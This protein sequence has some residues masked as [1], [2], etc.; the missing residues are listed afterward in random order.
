MGKEE[1]GPSCPTPT[2]QAGKNTTL[3]ACSSVTTTEKSVCACLW[4]YDDLGWPGR[5]GTVC[6]A[7]LLL[8]SHL[9]TSL[10]ISPALFLPACFPTVSA[11]LLLPLG[12]SCNPPPVLPH[13]PLA[14]FD[15]SWGTGGQRGRETSPAADLCKCQRGAWREGWPDTL[16]LAF[17]F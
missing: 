3:A 1:K 17:S 12:W 13:G 7:C 6:P 10:Q 15:M 2:P 9:R 11:L 4:L 8:R 14:A 16:P 5:L